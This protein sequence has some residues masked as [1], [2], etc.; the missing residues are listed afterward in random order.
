MWPF[1]PNIER[2]ESRRNVKGL[3][4]ALRHGD[5]HVRYQAIKAL[6]SLQD[7]RA[8]DALLKALGN[9]SPPVRENAAYALGESTMYHPRSAEPLVEALKD[10]S[11]Q[12]RHAAAWA[13]RHVASPN[14][15][16]PLVDSLR[17]EDPDVRSQSAFA[18]GE[19]RDARAVAP[20]IAALDDIFVRDMAAIALGKLGDI[21]AVEALITA[22]EES[23]GFG[24]YGYATRV[25]EALFRL[26][27]IR[28]AAPMERLAAEDNPGRRATA[29][30]SD[31]RNGELG[32]GLAY[33]NCIRTLVNTAK[34]LRYK[35]AVYQARCASDRRRMGS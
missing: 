6:R 22:L 26:E 29:M 32:L 2:M 31:I 21:R 11:R 14:T 18:L 24:Q 4:R 7:V 17:D 5:W 27:D 30:E 10:E 13:L 25:A 1:K 16:E 15:L 20:L 33:D 35:E 9:E 28:A 19:L 8:I 23:F 34:A 3:T 12:V